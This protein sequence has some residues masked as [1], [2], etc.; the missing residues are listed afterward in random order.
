MDALG[1]L[2]EHAAVGKIYL[3]R[4]NSLQ[5]WTLLALGPLSGQ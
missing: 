5:W 4:K 3:E 2:F 1:V